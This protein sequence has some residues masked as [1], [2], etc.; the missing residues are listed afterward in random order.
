MKEN[1]SRLLTSTFE[2]E[3]SEQAAAWN[4]LS[5]QNKLFALYKKLM[6]LEIND[7]LKSDGF[8]KRYRRPIPLDG[9]SKNAMSGFNV[10]LARSAKAV[11][12][13]FFKNL[14]AAGVLA[15]PLP[16]S[17][18]VNFSR[19][20]SYKD[21]S[22][23]SLASLVWLLHTSTAQSKPRCSFCQQSKSPIHFPGTSQIWKAS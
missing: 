9:F 7:T 1:I 3:D 8:V 16:F 14:T 21:L 15:S 20:E 2:S 22:L 10:F 23:F 19:D 12:Q 18:G 11:L 4:A 13:K 5:Q 17:N 6:F